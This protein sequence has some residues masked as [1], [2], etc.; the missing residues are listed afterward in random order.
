VKRIA[1]F[2]GGLLLLLAGCKPAAKPAESGAPAQKTAILAAR[3]EGESPFQVAL[4]LEPAQ[5]ISQKPTK[6]RFTVTGADGKP[7][8]GLAASVSLV[9]PLMD[10][11]KNEFA[12]KEVAPGVYEGEG[13]FTMEDEWEVF[14]ALQRGKEKPARH[15]FNVRVAP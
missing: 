4:A 14:L 6:F 10:M 2:A 5:P 12:A 8:A 9:M 1:I 11:G 13:A 7:A 3:A 15:V